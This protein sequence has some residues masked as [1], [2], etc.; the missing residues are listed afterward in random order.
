MSA[1]NPMHPA[2]PAGVT[3]EA[4]PARTIIVVASG[5]PCKGVGRSGRRIRCPRPEPLDGRGCAVEALGWASAPTR[6]K[7]IR[8]HGS[9]GV[10]H[11]HRHIPCRDSHHD[12]ARFGPYVAKVI[13]WRRAERP[14]VPSNGAGIQRHISDRVTA[15]EGSPSGPRPPSTA[16]H[17]PD[18]RPHNGPRPWPSSP[19]PLPRTRSLSSA[20]RVP[21]TPG[22]C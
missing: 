3:D 12:P 22:S 17:S 19:G 4:C 7:P 20:I 5:W 9:G 2:A 18:L 11:P 21:A 6:V 1:V 10:R 13:M 16:R 15:S 14:P 8:H